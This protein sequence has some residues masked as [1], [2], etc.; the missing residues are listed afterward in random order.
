MPPPG[1]QAPGAYPGQPPMTYPGQSPMPPPGQQ[2]VPSYP[3]Y[4]GSG[5]VTPTVPPAKVSAIQ[6]EF[7]GWTLV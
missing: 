1:Q 4:S 7:K 5:T 2:P 3:G 6:I